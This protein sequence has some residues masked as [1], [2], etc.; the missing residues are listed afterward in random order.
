MLIA[1]KHNKVVRWICGAALLLMLVLFV[2]G[3]YVKWDITGDW[4]G[5]Y[6]LVGPE[7]R[8]TV[9]DD[10]FPEDAKYL[11]GGITLSWFKKVVIVDNCDAASGSCLNVAWNEKQGRGYVKNIYHDGSK[12][13]INLSRFKNET[14]ALSSGIFVGGGLPTGDPDS[15]ITNNDET[16]MTYFDGKRWN[17]IWCNVNEAI[18][19]ASDPQK[20]IYPQEW[21]FLGSRVLG[22]RSNIITIVSEHR[23][24]MDE[25]P[26]KVEKYFFYEAGDKYFTLV[27]M[28][29]NVG[30][31]PVSFY[32]LYGDEPWVGHFGSS[33]G[34]VGWLQKRLVK[35]EEEIDSGTNNFAGLLDYGNDLAG[36]CHNYTCMA[37]F[38]EWDKPSK[39]DMVYYSNH[40]G[41]FTPSSGGKVPLCSNTSRFLG[42]QW[43]PRLLAPKQSFSF[44]L[45]VGMANK[46]PRTGLPVKPVT[47]LN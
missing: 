47:S 21:E 24:V 3:L 43:G 14:G 7:R 22:D 11:A 26:L 35:T 10:L 27:T 5:L 23:F 44:T 8:L 39:P 37:N 2:A 32:Y 20:L 40:S 19:P 18:C 41:K 6:V 25:E 33:E 36:E 46:D 12:L 1:I 31:K 30:V 17:H 34:N 45:A 29:T 42:L 38:I 16:G 9:T 4:E 28:V 13:L 15:L